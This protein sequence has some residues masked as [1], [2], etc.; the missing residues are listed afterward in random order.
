MSNLATLKP[1][2]KGHDPRRNV[3]G[4][5]QSTKNK[6]LNTYLQEYLSKS[7]NTPTGK[8]K[9]VQLIAERVVHEA[10]KGDLKAIKFVIERVNGKA[11]SKSEMMRLKGVSYDEEPERIITPEEEQELDRFFGR[12]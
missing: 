3:K 7:V 1:F 2:R 9:V 8:K 4:R 5:I 12:H 10:L 11:I 6:T